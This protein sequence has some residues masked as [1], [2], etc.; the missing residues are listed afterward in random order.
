MSYMSKEQN[1]KSRRFELQLR[2]VAELNRRFEEAR[3]N[4]LF[5]DMKNGNA[6]VIH[7]LPTWN[8]STDRYSVTDLI[9]KVYYGEGNCLEDVAEIIMGI[10]R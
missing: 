7:R 10:S 3:V 1:R 9:G 4:D 5:L 2:I 8:M 6:I